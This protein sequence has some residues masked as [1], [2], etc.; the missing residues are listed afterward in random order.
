ML[1]PISRRVR[2]TVY[3]WRAS[4]F[5]HALERAALIAEKRLGNQ[6]CYFMAENLLMEMEKAQVSL[7]KPAGQ[8]YR[9]PLRWPCNI[10]KKRMAMTPC[11]IPRSR[12]FDF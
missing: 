12:S 2:E 6:I 3:R 1:W 8:Q 11:A 5:E 4:R 7:V 10:F 9:L